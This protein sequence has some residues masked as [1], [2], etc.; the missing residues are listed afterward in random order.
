M[1]E[2]KNPDIKKIIENHPE[3]KLVIETID[4]FKKNGSEKNKKDIYFAL[5]K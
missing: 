1:I 2:A 3:Y 4:Y 5:V